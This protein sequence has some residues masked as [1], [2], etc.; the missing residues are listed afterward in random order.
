MCFSRGS[1]A[2]LLQNPLYIG[3]V[4]HRGELFD[5]EHEPVVDLAMWDEVQQLLATNRRERLHGERA[6]SP[7]L[8][9]GLITDADGRPMTP[10]F[11]TKGS[12]Q[13]RYYVTRLKPGEDRRAAWRVPAGD[14][15]RAVLECTSKFLTSAPLKSLMRMIVHSRSTW[16][17]TAFLSSAR[18]FWKQKVRVRLGSSNIIV[19][20]GGEPEQQI[21]APRGFARRGNEMKLVVLAEG[22]GRRNPILCSSSFSP[23]RTLRGRRSPLEQLIRLVSNYSKRHLWQLLRLNWLAPDIVTAIVEGRQ[24]PSLTGR[25]LLRAADV[26]LSWEEQRRSFGFN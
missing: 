19:S 24:P 1:L 2:Q 25:R 3:K 5:G 6:R 12:R 18:C 16:L 26:P 23:M 14:I 13:H 22:R 11:T 4:S 17:G 9:T 20:I 21:A 8:L 10:V 7:S 15:D